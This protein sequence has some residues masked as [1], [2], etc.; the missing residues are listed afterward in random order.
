MVLN[1]FGLDLQLYRSGTC[2]QVS[3]RQT[4]LDGAN[5]SPAVALLESQKREWLQNLATTKEELWP[6]CLRQDRQTLL[7]L[8]AYCVARTVS[9][10]KSKSDVDGQGK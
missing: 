8:L 10:V 7:D 5:D 1:E 2:V 9:A 3:T 4:Y 6:W